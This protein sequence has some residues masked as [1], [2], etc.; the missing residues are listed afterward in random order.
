MIEVVGALLVRDGRLLL[1]LRASHKE[2]APDAWDLVGGHVEPGET[3]LAA[4]R[5]EVLEEI[6]LDVEAAR[7][8]DVVSFVHKGEPGRLHLFHVTGW[9]GTPG[10]A[11][12]EHVDLR[13]FSA[14]D[15]EAVSNLAFEAYREIFIRGLAES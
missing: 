11:N 8:F 2:V 12:D 5:R 15:L 14:A 3:P 1:G 7:P 9:R 13:W 4:L 6:G 10:I